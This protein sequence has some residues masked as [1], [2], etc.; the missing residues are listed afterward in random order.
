VKLGLAFVTLIIAGVAGLFLAYPAIAAATCPSCFGFAGTGRN[1][2]VEDGMT[3][4]QRAE[5]EAIIQ[6]ARERVSVFYGSRVGNPRILLCATQKCYDG[7]GGRLPGNSDPRSE[8]HLDKHGK[9]AR[10]KSANSYQ[11]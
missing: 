1:V 6:Q 11:G 2:Y 8:R 9:T 4:G 10:A 7:I 3:P 5:A